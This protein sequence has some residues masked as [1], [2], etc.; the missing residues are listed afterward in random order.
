MSKYRELTGLTGAIATALTGALLVTLPAKPAHAQAGSRL[1]GWSAPAPTPPER[2]MGSY[3]GKPG[4][5]IGLLYEARQKDSSYSK[6]CDRAISRL[7]D[8]IQADP[9]LKG[10]NWTR[11]SKATCESVG[12]NFQSANSPMDMCEKMEANQSYVVRYDSR[13][14]VGKTSYE[15]Q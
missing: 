8:K 14:T 4:N 12:A 5:Y 13:G 3:P 2:G 1:C 11:H 15:K 10:L 7:W 6:N 9:T